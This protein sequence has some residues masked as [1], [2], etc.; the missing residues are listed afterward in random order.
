MS[1]LPIALFLKPFFLFIASVGLLGV[2]HL[3]IRFF[4]SGWLKRLLLY[5]IY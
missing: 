4:P 2:R 1:T 3:V 5:K